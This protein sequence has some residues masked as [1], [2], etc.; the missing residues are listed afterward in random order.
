MEDR[1]KV[2]VEPNERQAVERA[3]ELLVTILS[4]ASAGTHGPVSVALAGG[5]TPRHLYEHLS[6][7][8]RIE[9]V[10]WPDLCVFFGDER[11]VPPNHPESN[12][13]MAE[14]TLIARVPLPVDRVH[15]MEGDA[16]D[17]D[18]AAE[19]YEQS[20]RRA[21]PPGEDGVPAFDLVLLGMGTDGHTASLFPETP[22]LGEQ[23]R[24]VV[25]QHVAI[26][27]RRRL[28]FTYPLLNAAKHVLFLITGRD[29]ADAVRLL[30]RERPGPGHPLPA[31]R[32]SPRAGTLHLVLDADAASRAAQRQSPGGS[33]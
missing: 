5:T 8:D 3:A 32:V 12:Y 22:A 2:L 1:R 24:L 26:H 30:L 14:Q 4:E 11:D 33:A 15:P 17:L 19:R 29:K 7:A 28:T 16:A 23:H 25:A 31:G 27:G 10:N 20:I 9:R 13:H 6:R 18:G 21:V